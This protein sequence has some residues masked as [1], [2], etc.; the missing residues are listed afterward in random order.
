MSITASAVSNSALGSR[1]PAI[2][3]GLASVASN[4]NVAANATSR[5]RAEWD[6][7]RRAMG[8]SLCT[9]SFAAR[10]CILVLLAMGSG[11]VGAAGAFVVEGVLLIW[12][13][14]CAVSRCALAVATVLKSS[15]G[16]VSIWALR[17]C[18]SAALCALA[19][20]TLG[21]GTF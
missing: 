8:S 5:A 21:S 6:L 18:L 13:L 15:S 11:L 19:D 12:A 9:R 10:N 14:R 7:V 2:L 20:C 17:V 3:R 1:R 16:V 4:S